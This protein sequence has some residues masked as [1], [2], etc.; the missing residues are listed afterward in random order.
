MT[1]DNQIPEENLEEITLK[2][3]SVPNKGESTENRRLWWPPAD[4]KGTIGLLTVRQFQ[5]YP[6]LAPLSGMNPNPIAT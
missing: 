3:Q 6:W 2:S 1:T 5:W 4:D